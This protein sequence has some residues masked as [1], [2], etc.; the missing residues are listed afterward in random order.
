[1]KIEEIF[2]RS[3]E[4]II[5]MNW[6][7]EDKH[8]CN[9]IIMHLPDQEPV[10]FMDIGLFNACTNVEYEEYEDSGCGV[11]KIPFLGKLVETFEDEEIED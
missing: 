10:S 11:L 1:M 7:S 4:I 8:V 5:E 9:D 6:D 3:D 2:R